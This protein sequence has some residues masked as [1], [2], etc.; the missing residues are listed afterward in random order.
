M[1]LLIPIFHSLIVASL[2]T[3][4]SFVLML[5][6][7]YLSVFKTY[8]GQTLVEILLLLPLVLP[9][10]IVGLYLIQVFGKYGCLSFL[11]NHLIF[12]LSGAVL[13]TTVITLPLVFQGLKAGFSGVPQELIDVALV[14]GAN[15]FQIL[16]DVIFPCSW[17]MILV[18][19]LLAFCRA[20]GEFGASLMVAG[21]IPGKTDTLSNAIYFAVQ[22]SENNKAMLLA[23]INLIIGIIV[24]A[25]ILLLGKKSRTKV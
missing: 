5:P 9:P 10:T 23:A 11:G 24:L 15:R 6:L 17:T 18:S 21:Y 3:L 20:L 7:A 19:I 13:A 25:L 14:Y 4:F 1:M 22:N 2:A 16:L 8:R 12:S